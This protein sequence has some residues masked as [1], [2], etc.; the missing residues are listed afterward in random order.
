MDKKLFAAI[1]VG[2]TTVAVSLIDEN[3]TVIIKDGFINPQVKFG[4]DVISRITLSER[5]DNLKMM[6]DLI[7]KSIEDSLRKMLGNEYTSDDLKFGIISANTV[8]AAI[9]LGKE[10]TSLG[11]APFTC[12]F[13]EN[14]EI[15]LL[16]KVP[17]KVLAGAS[18]FIGG[19]SVI[20]AFYKFKKDKTDK[21]DKTELLIDMGTNGEMILSHEGR[22]TAISAACGPAFENST[23]STGIYGKTTL[24]AISGLISTGEL[25]R[26]LFLSDEFIKSGK[27]ITISGV[28]IHLTEKI[29]REIQLAVAAIY[30]SLIFLLEKSGIKATDVD[31]LYVAGGFGF[32]MSLRDAENLGII[33]SQLIDK[34]EISGNTSLL[35][36]EMLIND[37]LKFGTDC[38]LGEYD[39]FR[40]S[41][42]TFQPGGDKMYEDLFTGNM[43]FEKR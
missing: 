43:T 6:K 1:D 36:S 30:A 5:N 3:N 29:I 13:T 15:T 39:I 27:D 16:D 33:P 22:L 32:H 40:K 35:G 19:D 8:M 20:G 23:R 9:I 4:S 12:P 28:K 42:V 26:D 17:V 37:C 10:I 7:I 24:S 41:I 21:K 11:K 18:A 2:T 34:T 31:R 14:E 25:R 38:K